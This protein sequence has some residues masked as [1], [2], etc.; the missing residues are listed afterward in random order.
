MAPTPT[1]FI[2]Q[3]H[4]NWQD[5]LCCLITPSLQSTG[6]A[7]ATRSERRGKEGVGDSK[8]GSHCHVEHGEASPTS[9]VL[10][11]GPRSC[12]ETPLLSPPYPPS[13]SSLLSG[14]HLSQYMCH[15]K[16]GRPQFHPRDKSEDTR[17]KQRSPSQARVSAAFKRNLESQS[18]HFSFFS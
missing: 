10:S 12:R 18:Y 5:F 13:P 16:L 4:L 8:P 2:F 15:L 11:D 14:L 3:P 17:P 6:Q 7:R 9:S 1:C